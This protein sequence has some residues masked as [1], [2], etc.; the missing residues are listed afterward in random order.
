MISGAMAVAALVPTQGRMV[1]SARR[2]RPARLLALVIDTIFFSLIWSVANFVFGVTQ[3]TSG[4]PVSVGGSAAFSTQ[5]SI[6]WVWTSVIYL[7]YFIG[8]ES[9]FSATPGKG[10]CGLRVATVDGRRLAVRTVVWRNL[11]RVVDALPIL[12]LLG[13]GSVLLT[14]HSQRLGDLVAGTTVVHRE[15]V[16]NSEAARHAT[17]RQRAWFALAVAGLLAF[18]CAFG[19]FGRP[20]LVIEGLYNQRLLMDPEIVGYSLGSPTWSWGKVVYP[21][22]AT[23][24]GKHCTGYIELDWYWISGW[25]Q[26]NGELDCFPS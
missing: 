22:T 5:T 15:S 21:I 11:V 20:A 24:P 8:F 18:T 2:A 17:R 12:Y 19:Y 23:E 13:G 9:V 10:L 14:M 25:Q 4:S 6:P 7:G 16:P 26:S 1:E 3:V